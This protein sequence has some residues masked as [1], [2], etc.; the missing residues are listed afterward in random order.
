METGNRTLGGRLVPALV[1]ASRSKTWPVMKTSCRGCFDPPTPSFLL[2]LT[3]WKLVKICKVSTATVQ[4]SLK[5]DSGISAVKAGRVS[6]R[7]IYGYK[8]NK[9]QEN[10]L[11]N[12]RET[13]SDT[14]Y[15]H[16]SRVATNFK[17]ET[18]K[19]KIL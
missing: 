5:G 19:K 8:S 3:D 6:I 2:R 11:F 7:H 16:G 12:S 15:P 14:L 1:K 4:Q 9:T 18:T 17:I 10:P 13:I